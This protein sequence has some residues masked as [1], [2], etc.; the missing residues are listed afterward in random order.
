MASV[1][2]VLSEEPIIECHQD[3][4]LSLILFVQL[5]KLCD[6]LGLKLIVSCVAVTQ[7]NKATNLI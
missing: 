1:S 7:V 6:I 3:Q 2:D 5:N 4:K